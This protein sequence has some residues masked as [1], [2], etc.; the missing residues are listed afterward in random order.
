MH[1]AS[2]G[3]V[4]C[5]IQLIEYGAS[6]VSIDQQQRGIR[7]FTAQSVQISSAI[8]AYSELYKLK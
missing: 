1:A 4:D 8:L 3:H 2:E 6:V 5:V 7:L